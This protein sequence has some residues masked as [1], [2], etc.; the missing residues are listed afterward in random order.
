MGAVWAATHEIT[1]RRVAVKMLRASAHR[2]VEL[3]RRLVREAR[4]A[5]AVAHPNVVEVLDVLDVDA[6]TPAMV[7]DLLTGE[8]LAERLSRQRRL[9][10]EQCSQLLVPALSA[11]GMAHS[12]GIVHRDLKPANL[13]VAVGAD[14]TE[15]V[16]V[17]DFGIAK[18][19]ADP[20]APEETGLTKT[21]ATLGTPCY[22]SPEQ[23]VGARD[24]DHLSDVWAFGVI[25]YEC[26]SG[27]RP[28]EGETVGQVVMALMSTGI[29]P[30]ERLVPGLPPEVSSCIGRMLSR[31][32]AVRPTDLRELFDILRRHSD[33]SAPEFGPPAAAVV[34]PPTEAAAPEPSTRSSS[35]LALA[36]TIGA[37]G[38]ASPASPAV[39]PPSRRAR[40][41]L[42]PLAAATAIGVVIA[43]LAWQGA[44]TS[45]GDAPVEAKPA[46]A[47]APLPRPLAVASEERPEAAQPDTPVAREGDALP[48]ASGKPT[49]RAQ[50]SSSEPVQA[51]SA[52]AVPEEPPGVD[53]KVPASRPAPSLT[54]REYRGGLAE[55]PPF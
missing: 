12:R 40:R 22:M 53:E 55:E 13:F 17:L 24:V 45:R 26:V 54:A 33:V 35:Q 29:M 4:A 50:R 18:L 2:D 15:C 31:E 48:A 28:I 11:V 9:S 21:G 42:A 19:Y 32:R 36:S 10:L 14:G 51:P 37:G 34:R 27:V 20:V 38:E 7:M 41:W 52:A 16:K 44:L 49:R 43:T 47:A 6:E 8:T 1:G 25:A 5:A 30:V 3:S 23:A 39:S 46:H